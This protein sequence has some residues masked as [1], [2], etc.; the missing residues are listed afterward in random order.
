MLDVDDCGWLV[1]HLFAVL[2]SGEFDPTLDSILLSSLFSLPFAD[3]L[4]FLEVEAE[5]EEL[6]VSVAVSEDVHLPHISI[7]PSK[8]KWLPK[9]SCNSINK[10]CIIK[11]QHLR[12]SLLG[13]FGLKIIAYPSSL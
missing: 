6:T 1:A 4:S 9:V 2:S 3:C 5:G 11:Y 7:A 13:V 8:T 10:I 12:V